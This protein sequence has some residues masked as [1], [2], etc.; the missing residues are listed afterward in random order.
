MTLIR[1]ADVIHLNKNR[2]TN[3]A[4]AGINRFV[5]AETNPAYEIDI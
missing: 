3:P 1:F 2:I 4:A 5:V